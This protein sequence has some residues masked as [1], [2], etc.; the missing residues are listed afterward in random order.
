MNFNDVTV[1][2][3]T[4]KS[5]KVIFNCLKSIKHFK[6]II[7]FDNS[8]DVLLQKKI[9]KI[10]P[11][12]KFVIS[13]KNLGY[14]E[15]NNRILK[16]SKTKN[17]FILSPDTILQKNCEIELIKIAKKLKNFSII[18]PLAKENNYGYFQNNFFKKKK[19]YFEVDYVKGFAMLF[20]LD[21]VKKIGMF[22]KNIF[23]YLEEIDLCRRLRLK[24]NKIYICKKAN[25][26][27]LGAKSSN[28]GFDYE[29][30]RN[31]HWM[32]SKVYYDKKYN[33]NFYIYIK[34]FFELNISLLKLLLNLFLLKK[35]KI[36]ISYLR[37][38]GLFNS[39]V[40][41]KS[42]YRP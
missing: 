38:S 14:G 1:G 23:L 8:N 32:W 40:G 20:N 17:V 35:N 18:A 11:F 27:H 29:K 6:K 4:F 28:L 31:W 22:D 39:L 13:D 9:K 15:G 41:K 42:W 37:L 21:K 12:I 7:I 25:I 33:N 34:Y 26:T 2:I 24:K 3:V 10:Y 16:L 5:E 19:D 30:C 36:I